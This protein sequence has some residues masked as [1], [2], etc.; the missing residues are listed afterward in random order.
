MFGLANLGHPELGMW[1]LSEIPSVR[2]PFSMGIE[3]DLL[4]TGY[5]QVSFWVEAARET[6]SIRAAERLL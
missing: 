6:G 4:F 5:F 2:L 1:S 3:R